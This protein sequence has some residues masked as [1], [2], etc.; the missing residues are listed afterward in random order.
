M[1]DWVREANRADDPVGDADL[2]EMLAVFALENLLDPESAQAPAE[3]L[4]LRD[5]REEARRARDFAQ[6]DHIRNQIRS[7]KRPRRPAAD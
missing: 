2:R 4:A 7:G 5:A 1:F 6:A 3:V